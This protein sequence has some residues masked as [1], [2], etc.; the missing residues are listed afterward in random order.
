MSSDSLPTGLHARAGARPAHDHT[1][2]DVPASARMILRLLDKLQWGAL[3]LRTP[4]GSVLLYGDGG[5]P[6][7]GA[8]PTSN[9][10]VAVRGVANNGPTARYATAANKPPATLPIG[11]LNASMPPPTLASATT[12]MT[13]KPTAVTR[14]PSAAIQTCGPA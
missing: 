3:R 1:H 10:T 5:K 8:R 2:L 7:N 14:K 4:D 11:L 12:V 13:G 6:V 9:E